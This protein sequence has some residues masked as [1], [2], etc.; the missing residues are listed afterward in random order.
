MKILKLVKKIL[1]GFVEADDT[2]AI[3]EKESNKV[4]GS[5]GIHK[6]LLDENYDVEIQR[7]IGYV[8]NK[9]YWGKGITTE[10]VKEVIK[11]IVEQTDIKVI[12]CYHYDHNQRSARVIEKCGFVFVE[13]RVLEAP[14]LNKEFD[15]K[16]YKIII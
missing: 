12:H 2:Y 3:V 14:L 4:I 15:S 1:K 7:E 10:A 11:Y 5:V 8:L 16:V 6:G 13:N 9:D